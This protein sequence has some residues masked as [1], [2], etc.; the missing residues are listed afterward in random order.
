MANQM[1]FADLARLCDKEAPEPDPGLRAPYVRGSDT[2]KAAA[3]S[4]QPIQG[5]LR[6]RVY[7][8]IARAGSRGM[9][10]DEVEQA[11]NLKHQ[12]ASARV[13]E[14]FQLGRLRKVGKRP[15]SSGRQ[16]WIYVA[17]AEPR[18]DQR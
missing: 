1:T 10:C 14:L 16:A 13:R 7:E 12:T 6:R 17:S 5:D 8:S 2:S 15:T 4:V 9:T 3:E 11:T 18:N